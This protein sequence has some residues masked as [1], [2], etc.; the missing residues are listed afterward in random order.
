ME[1]VRGC[2]RRKGSGAGC[3]MRV[4]FTVLDAGPTRRQEHMGPDLN[5]RVVCLMMMP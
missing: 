2:A 3:A 5:K 4:C 1:Y